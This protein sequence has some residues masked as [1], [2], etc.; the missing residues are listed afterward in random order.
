MIQKSKYH[1]EKDYPAQ[2]NYDRHSVEK[3]QVEDFVS[4][5]SNYKWIG[6]VAQDQKL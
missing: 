1:R 5:L 2:H 6:V 3:T 4:L